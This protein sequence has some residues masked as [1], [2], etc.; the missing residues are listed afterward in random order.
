MRSN[1]D[2]SNS[3]FYFPSIGTFPGKVSLTLP[4][5]TARGRRSVF[6]ATLALSLMDGSRNAASR[7]IKIKST[8][9][10]EASDE[11][12]S[13]EATVVQVNGLT[14]NLLDSH[15]RVRTG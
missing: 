9:A 15:R 12:C 1:L 6:F 8:F 5:V 7:T 11:K 4:A 14:G 10:M 13:A 2:K 3:G